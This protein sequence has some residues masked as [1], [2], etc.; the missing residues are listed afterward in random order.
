MRILTEKQINKYN[1]K[2]LEI[3][4]TIVYSRINRMAYIYNYLIFH[5]CNSCIWYYLLVFL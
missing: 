1:Y 3:Q 5:V 4:L 2:Q